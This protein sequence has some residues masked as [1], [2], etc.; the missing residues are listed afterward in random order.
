MTTS[1]RGY[2][3]AHQQRRRILIP[4]AWFTDC[5]AC[6]ETMLPEQA[7]DLDHSVPLI[8]NSASL[9]DRVLHARCNRGAGAS[10]LCKP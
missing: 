1:Q 4:L 8:E 5:P 7:L 10:M 6:G 9:G 3:H 2:G